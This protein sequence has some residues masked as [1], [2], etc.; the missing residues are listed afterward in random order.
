MKNTRKMVMASILVAVAVVGSMVSFP[1]LGSKCSP[2]QHIVNILAAVM[3]GPWYG[4]VMAFVASV[5]RVA[6]GLGTFMAFP[7]SMCGAMLA[8]IMYRFYKKLPAACIGEL[9]GTSIIGGMLA[10]PVALFV[11]G[12]KTAALFAYIVPFLISS[13]GGTVIAVAVLLTLENTRMLKKF[14]V[15]N[16]R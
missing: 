7:G 14:E 9:F 4:V 3:L 13:A 6:L 12:N 16:D 8:G 5:I 15:K 10:Y 11:M 1:V 2:V